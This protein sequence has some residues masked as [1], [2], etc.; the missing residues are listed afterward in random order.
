MEKQKSENE[1][2]HEC[3]THRQTDRHSRN[4]GACERSIERRERMVKEMRAMEERANAIQK[5][6]RLLAFV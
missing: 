1:D 6:K 2:A 4:G 3:H 5:R